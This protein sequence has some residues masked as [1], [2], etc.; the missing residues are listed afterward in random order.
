MQLSN[1][2]LTLIAATSATAAPAS[3]ASVSMAAAAPQWT[4]ENMKRVCKPTDTTCTF[5]FGINTRVSGVA[6]QAC[7]YVVKG[8]P[9]Y[10]AKGGPTKC[11]AFTVTSNWSN[12]FGNDPKDTFT[13]MSVINYAKNQIVYPA[14]TDKQLNG[15]AVV[16]PNQSY[17]VQ[18][19]PK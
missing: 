6:T 9:A 18:A 19:L 17:P 4:I 1:V 2:L 13:S 11:G 7:T 10:K 14:Y 3:P 5:T 12:Q 16:T 8:N 15:G